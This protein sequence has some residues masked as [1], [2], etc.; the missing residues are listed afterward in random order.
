MAF[1]TWFTSNYFHRDNYGKIDI[2]IKSCY[3]GQILLAEALVRFFLSRDWRWEE[4]AAGREQEVFHRQIIRW[5]GDCDR[6]DNLF[7]IHR[8]VNIGIGQK[9]GRKA[10]ISYFSVIL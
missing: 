2:L 7:G 10:G 4:E 8:L 9:H 5:F 1:F 3:S 6:P